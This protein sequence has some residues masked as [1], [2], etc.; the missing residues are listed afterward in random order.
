MG[1]AWLFAGSMAAA[2]LP[3]QE[4]PV[5]PLDLPI[6][7][8]FPIRAD[9][10]VTRVSIVNPTVADVVVVSEREVVINS[11][12]SGETDAIIW[13]ANGTR[14]HYRISVHSPADRKQISIAVHFA[15]VRKDALREIGVSGLWRDNRVRTGTGIF[16]SDAPFTDDGKINLPVNA[17]FG[18]FLSDLGTD[19]LLAFL[20]A[21]EQKGNARFLAEPNLMAGN[22]DSATFLAGGELPIPVVQGGAS[23][24]GVTVQ[25][26]EF[27]IRLKFVG[28]IISDSLIKLTVTPEVSSLD[29][30]NAITLQ[31]FRVPAF[32]T[33]RVMT[34]L[35]VR[36]NQSLIISGMFAGEDEQVRTGLPLLMNIPIL[37]QLFSSTRF[38][39]NESELLVVVTPV[40]VDP[41]RPRP[42]DTLRLPTDTTRPAIDALGR[43]R[44]PPR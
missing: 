3:A 4:G 12:A 43:R 13:L 44:P 38:Q 41:L 11:L 25:Y 29:F 30:A 28:E 7:R 23:N 34:T 6:G 21:Q 19:N 10:A 32:R 35:D 39:R 31:G 37:G 40:V 22:K 16:R 26:R 27:G 9:T 8:S 14:T 1:A 36:Q 15:E 17:G 33:R 24:A 5:T 2:Q 18:T 42:G 20:D